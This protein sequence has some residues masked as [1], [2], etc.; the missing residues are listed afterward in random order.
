MPPTDERLGR[1]DGAAPQV[2]LGQI[3]EQ[4]RLAVDVALKVEFNVVA[5]KPLEGNVI[6]GHR[7]LVTARALGRH[8]GFIGAMK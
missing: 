7:D 3:V 6:M 1:D 8:D 4:Q 5:E 2:D